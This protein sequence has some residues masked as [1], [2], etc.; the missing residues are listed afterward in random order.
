MQR[1]LNEVLPSPKERPLPWVFMFSFPCSSR[2][3]EPRTQKYTAKPLRCTEAFFSVEVRLMLAK[4]SFKA[5]QAM[6]H[7]VSRIIPEEQLQP[8][9]WVLNIPE[10]VRCHIG[11]IVA[12]QLQRGFF[13]DSDTSVRLSHRLCSESPRKKSLASNCNADFTEDSQNPGLWRP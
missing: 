7:G 1:Q 3:R 13:R 6:N 5:A 11:G 12:F 2:H 4:F 8:L 10:Q 9:P